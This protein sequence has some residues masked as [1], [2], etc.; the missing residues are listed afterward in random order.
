MTV[1]YFW[2]P[3]PSASF[4]DSYVLTMPDSEVD[5]EA[6]SGGCDQFGVDGFG[7]SELF[8]RIW[9]DFDEGSDGSRCESPQGSCE[10]HEG[11]SFRR[12]TGALSA[13]G[14]GEAAAR[15]EDEW[16]GVLR[17]GRL[18]IYFRPF[19]ACKRDE[20]FCGRRSRRIHHQRPACWGRRRRGCK[21]ARKLSGGAA[22]RAFVHRVDR[23]W[24]F[25]AYFNGRCV[26]AGYQ[27]QRNLV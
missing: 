23:G 21:G 14:G 11:V 6:I 10:N 15:H 22:A 8:A 3:F 24:R 13:R 12:G 26:R 4:V 27:S 16:Y 19:P 9:R 17:R 7:C 20:G 25:A 5:D 2:A 1:R 18:P